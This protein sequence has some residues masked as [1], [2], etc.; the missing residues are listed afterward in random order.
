[1]PVNSDVNH[2]R[3][4]RTAEGEDSH[5]PGSPQRLSCIRNHVSVLFKKVKTSMAA[6]GSSESRAEFKQRALPGIQCL[7]GT[8]ASI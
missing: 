8:F 3:V 6:S 2:W 5:S 4:L 7:P 1:M